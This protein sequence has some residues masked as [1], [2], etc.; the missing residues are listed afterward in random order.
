[1]IVATPANTNVM[2]DITKPIIVD[3]IEIQTRNIIHNASF[4]ELIMSLVTDYTP[5]IDNLL[6][7]F[8]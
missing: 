3:E 6:P 1:M 2:S 4:E 5:Y 7:L 8:D